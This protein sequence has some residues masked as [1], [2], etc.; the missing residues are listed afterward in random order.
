MLL[1]WPHFWPDGCPPEEAAR[2]SGD[3]F[4]YV[5]TDPPTKRDCRPYRRQNS[6]RDFGRQ[7]C[8]ACG[9]SVYRSLDAVRAQRDRIPAFRQWHIAKAELQRDHGRIL[10]TPTC[11]N[12]DHHTW[13]VPV[14]VD[15][16]QLLVVVEG[17][18]DQNDG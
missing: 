6:T 4:L 5:R 11:V 1:T 9:L 16:R 13:W 18:E 14:D 8:E 12:P 7:E 10:A 15:A 3:V 17:T 2:A